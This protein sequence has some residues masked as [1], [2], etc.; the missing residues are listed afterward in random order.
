MPKYLLILLLFIFTTS[1]SFYGRAD[2]AQEEELPACKCPHCADAGKCICDVTKC[3]CAHCKAVVE[4]AAVLSEQSEEENN[5]APYY[6]VEGVCPFCGA[7]WNEKGECEVC[8]SSKAHFH[9]LAFKKIQEFK[10]TESVF[11]VKKVIG[12]YETSIPEGITALSK[13]NAQE[14]KLRWEDGVFA[15]FLNNPTETPASKLKTILGVKTLLDESSAPRLPD[16]FGFHRYDTTT[17][18]GLEVK[19][20]YGS[21]QVQ[22][23]WWPLMDYVSMNGYEFAGPFT[24][25]YL[26]DPS[27]TP[28]SE[29]RTKLLIPVKAKS[30]ATKSTA[31]SGSAVGFSGADEE[32][33]T[34]PCFKGGECKCPEGCGCAHCTA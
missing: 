2:E 31:S 17:A 3:G 16:G 33:P 23:Y 22:A 32:K 6:P 26:D 27:I 12:A 7:K 29:C 25:I 5:E 15:M 9:E 10:L 30:E 20:E 14:L 18:V 19:G 8:H 21:P 24:E 4:N 13:L 28:K 34:C 1:L 11:I